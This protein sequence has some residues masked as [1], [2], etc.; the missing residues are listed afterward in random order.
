MH[1]LIQALLRNE[2]APEDQVGYRRDVQLILADQRFIVSPL[3][4]VTHVDERLE[5]ERSVGLVVDPGQDAGDRGS[6]MF[7]RP[8]PFQPD[9]LPCKIAFP[10]KAAHCAD[11]FGVF[12]HPF[13]GAFRPI[14]RPDSAAFRPAPRA[15]FFDCEGVPPE[16]TPG[17]AC[18][19]VTSH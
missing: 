6:R 10:C 19:F 16:Q 5:S 18:F 11:P 12:L 1:R 7:P 15:L 2:I 14:F 8:V 17:F 9:S 4:G 13:P 3:V